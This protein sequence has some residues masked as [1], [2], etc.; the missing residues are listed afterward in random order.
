MLICAWV[1]VPLGKTVVDHVH[2]VL[3]FTDAYQVVIRF[4]ITMQETSRVDI[5]NT[6]DQLI[7]KHEHSVK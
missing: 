3:T 6:L 7:S 5:L 1:L 4:D 2:V